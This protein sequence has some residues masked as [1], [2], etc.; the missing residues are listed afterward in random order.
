MNEHTITKEQEK[1]LLRIVVYALLL[2]F[3]DGLTTN[4][5]GGFCDRIKGLKKFTI[6]DSKIRNYLRDY[7]SGRNLS[8]FIKKGDTWF[9]RDDTGV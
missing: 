9:I 4:E 7:K 1:H 5:I 6:H 3:P 8:V 2:A